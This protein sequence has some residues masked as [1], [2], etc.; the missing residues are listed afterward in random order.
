LQNFLVCCFVFIVILSIAGVPIQL[1]SENCPAGWDAFPSSELSFYKERMVL[2]NTTAQS[3]QSTSA[4]TGLRGILRTYPLF[5]Y[6]LLSFAFS[7]I[8]ALPYMLSAWGILPGN[9][10]ILYALK[11][12][13]GP[14][15]A[16]IMMTGV[17]EGRAG[18][19]N[20]QQRCRQWRAGWQWYLFIL[21]GVPVLLLLGIMLLPGALANFQGLPPG[22]L[23]SYVVTFVL[24]FFGTGL[25]EE[26]GWRGFALPRMQP[27]YGPLRG[28]LLLGVAWAFWHLLYFF[29]PGHGG[30]PGTGAVTLLANFSIFFLMVISLTIL[31]TWVYN[32]TRGS[33][34]IA[35]LLHAAIDTPQ[36]VWA[37]LFLAVGATNSSAG[38]MSL[39]LALLIPFGVLA[40]LIVILTRGRLGY[41]PDQELPLELK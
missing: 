20:L 24:V 1:A 37:P 6:F 29:G 32:R 21:L 25:P 33:I 22:F 18:V 17:I 39:N 31:F 13:A 10:T 41:Q 30:G 12:W 28:T 38:E 36:L 7:W 19:R 34:F 16:G 5:S 2:M 11:P 26:I 3:N 14:A 27:R 15:L 23:V 35:G 4:R 9:Y 8:V 40:L